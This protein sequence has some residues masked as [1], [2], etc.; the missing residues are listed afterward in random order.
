LEEVLA[1]SRE[2]GYRYLE[3]VA[4]RLLGEA[5]APADPAAA[6]GLLEAAVRLLGEVGARNEL[7]KALVAQAQCRRS[8]GDQTGARQLLERA[9]ALFATLGTLDEPSRVRLALAALDQRPSA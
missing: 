3:G 4:N 9:L 7:A 5:L 6:A 8:A 1:T 2:D